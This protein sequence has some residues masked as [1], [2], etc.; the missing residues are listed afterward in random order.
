[1]PSL[2][3]NIPLSLYI[4]LPWCI[5]KC[6][7]CD[8]NSH[9]LR[10]T[11]PETAYVNA[12][13]E[14]LDDYLPWIAHR[15]LISI[16][17]GGGTPSLFSPEAIGRLLEG[18]AHRLTWSPTIEITLEANPGTAEQARFHGYRAAGI[19]RLSLGVQS[20]QDD[21]LKTLGRI[22]GSK[23][24]LRAIEMGK[25]AG[26]RLN[27][28]L[29]FG[30]PDQTPADACHDLKKALD[31]QITHLSWYQLTIEPNTIFYK[32]TP[33]LPTEGVIAEIEQAGKAVIKSY[34][35]QQYE[36]SAYAK[37]GE[38]CAH[39]LNYWTFGDYIGIGAGAHSKLT[40]SDAGQIIRFSQVKMPE[41]YL[42]VE[43][44]RLLSKG[45]PTPLEP[46]HLP[47][48]FMLNAL[49][50]TEGIDIALFSERTGLA[51]DSAAPYLN[52]ATARGL[53][54]INQ[55]HIQPTALGKKYLNDLVGMFL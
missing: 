35:L 38:A 34:G 36:V 9:A 17:F 8:F 46:Q 16:F 53:L 5:Q 1:M 30:L 26:F 51:W 55:A 19:N 15:P 14:E 7:Y 25:E 47:F 37:A 24:A 54:Q 32:R 23:E 39:N 48:E 10:G 31:Y 50:L 12:L 11:I 33:V 44:R 22:H 52:K 13:L 6:P 41:E 21:K 27:V 28:D 2:E 29:M 3:S 43:K 4:H 42:K 40:L 20:L 18:V 49:R 45:F